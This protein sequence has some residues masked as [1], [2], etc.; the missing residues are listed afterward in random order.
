MYIHVHDI[1]CSFLSTHKPFLYRPLYHTTPHHCYNLLSSASPSLNVVT[2]SAMSLLL[3]HRVPPQLYR[4]QHVSARFISNR[5]KR[6]QANMQKYN[7]RTKGK[8]GED[9]PLF[10]SLMRK[11]YLRGEI[12]LECKGDPWQ[13]M[14]ESTCFC[15]LQHDTWR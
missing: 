11:L 15:R 2:Q 9:L 7:N 8:L 1:H 13:N 5:K 3:L 10:H 12:T 14:S 6:H 4:R